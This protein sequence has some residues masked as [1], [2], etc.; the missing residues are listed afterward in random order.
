MNDDSVV[1]I[2]DLRDAIDDAHG[3]ANGPLEVGS[4]S[5][6]RPIDPGRWIGARIN[7]DCRGEECCQGAEAAG[8][9]GR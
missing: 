7:M 8:I 6:I 3:E 1:W 9:K 4:A 5:T 2:D